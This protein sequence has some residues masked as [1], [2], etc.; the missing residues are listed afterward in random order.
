MHT[1]PIESLEP[2][3]LM[4]GAV[5]VAN[6]TR[7]FVSSTRWAPEFKS[8]LGNYQYTSNPA[9]RY[10]DATYGYAMDDGDQM[11]ELPW[12]N[13]D[14]IS[15][16]F[17]QLVAVKQGDLAVRGVTVANYP[18]TAFA[19]D[20]ATSTA[21]WTLSRPLARDKVV[22]DLDGDAGGV[23]GRGAYSYSAPLDGDWTNPTPVARTDWFGQTYWSYQGYD[24]FPSGN[25]VP[26]GDFRF[27][28]NVLP[29]DA[30][31]S[32]DVGTADV[33]QVRNRVGTT[34]VN[35]GSYVWTQYGPFH[36]VN[37]SGDVTT[38]DVTLTRNRVGDNLNDYAEPPLAAGPAAAG[39]RDGHL[40]ELLA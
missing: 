30:N 33:T 17:D 23:E 18:T 8:Y 4:S 22:F 6:V 20:P 24:A 38:N 34:T 29:G 1:Q 16:R 9:H 21:T 10:G 36:D 27:R 12:V 25:G 15:I 39:D 5:A 14:Q 35:P 3:V 7:V 40:R 32:G 19:Y 31:R 26:G 11:N 2:R 13:L 28:V 37:G